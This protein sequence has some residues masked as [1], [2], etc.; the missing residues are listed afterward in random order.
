VT[1]T[2]ASG[3]FYTQKWT[4]AEHSGTHMDAPGHFVRG[5]RLVPEITPR[6]LIVPIVVVDIAARAARNPDAMV[7]VDDL[8]RFERR[9][10]RIPKGALVCMHSGWAAKVNDAQAFR[11]GAEPESYHFPG[12]GSEAAMWLARSRDVT[13]IGV[14]TLSLDPGNSRNVPVHWNFLRTD[15]YGLENLRNLNKI[16][17]RGATAYVGVI[18]W[19]RGS[20]GPVRVLATW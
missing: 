15:R 4:F 8:L 2:N 10:G 11:G 17:P 16:P 1:S 20:G 18:P 3:G 19:E 5:G 9:H 12:F 7:T 13:A 6:E 14:D